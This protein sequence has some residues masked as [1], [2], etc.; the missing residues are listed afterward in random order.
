MIRSVYGALVA[1]LAFVAAPASAQDCDR[2]C[3]AGLVTT[4]VDA[5]VA[6]DPSKLP[7][8]PGAR[9]TEDGK[10]AKLGEGLWQTVTG[11][12]AFRQDYLDSAKQIAAAQ[13]ELREGTVPVLYSLV[14]HLDGRRIAGVETL[15]YRVTPD[16]RFQPKELGKPIRGMNDAI[17][18]G[19]RQTRASLVATALTY[20]AG[21]KIGNFTDGG[22]PFAADA[23]RVENGVILAGE[24]C[25]R[26]DCGLYTQN[27]ILHPAIVR[28]V[29]AVD[30]ENG[31][32]LLWMNFGDTGSYGP[33]KALVAFEGFKIWGGQIRS[34]NAFFG[35]LPFSSARYWPSTDALP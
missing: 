13:V 29:A 24:G 15:V 10:E 11:K 28:S 31:T 14:L 22:T 2:A 30:E 12:A 19:K 3:M 20:P 26:G 21:L 6:H 16:S 27:I 9:V 5:L 34:I 35:F 32:V 25:G 18:K 33:G 7:L 8:A 1:A 23:Y 4:Y 17:P